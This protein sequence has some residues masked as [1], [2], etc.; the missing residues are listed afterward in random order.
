MWEAAAASVLAAAPTTIGGLAR[1]CSLPLLEIRGAGMM[2]EECMVYVIYV[3]GYVEV[4]S[5]SFWQ[6]FSKISTH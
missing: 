6:R 3:R 1:S 4:F 5:F 2:Q